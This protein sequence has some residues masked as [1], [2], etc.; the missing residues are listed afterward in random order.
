MSGFSREINETRLVGVEE[1]VENADKWRL[2]IGEKGS[3]AVWRDD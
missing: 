3:N 2:K 1:Q